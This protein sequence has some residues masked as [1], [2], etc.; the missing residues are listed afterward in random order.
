MVKLLMSEFDTCDGIA[1]SADMPF[2]QPNLMNISRP[3]VLR[4][5]YG[6]DINCVSKHELERVTYGPTSLTGGL[7]IDPRV[8]S[9]KPMST[10]MYDFGGTSKRYAT[11][12]FEKNGQKCDI[13][14]CDY[15]H[16]TILTYN[17][18]SPNINSQL[19]YHCD[20][21]YDHNGGFIMCGMEAVLGM[22]LSVWYARRLEECV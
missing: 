8:Y 22:L 13:F 17:V 3:A 16:C 4:T 14:E 21:I 9:T 15:N 7:A 2:A 10:S 6:L 19:S 11:E 1:L 12:K 20:C 18:H 5:Y